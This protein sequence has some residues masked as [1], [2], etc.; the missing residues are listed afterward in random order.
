MLKKIAVLGSTGSVGTQALEVIDTLGFNVVALAYGGNNKKL[1]KKQIEKY[2]PKIA[3]TDLIEA[4][5]VDADIFILSVVGEVGTKAAYDILKKGKILCIATKEVLVCEGKKIMDFAKKHNAEIRPLDSE[6]SAIWQCLKGE[7]K[8]E[9][10]KIFLTCSGGPFLDAKKWT[11]EKL[12]NVDKSKVLNHPKW[13]MGQKITVDSATLIN[14]ALEFIEVC[15]LFDVKPEQ[16][17]VV[18]HPEAIIHS[19]VQFKD[20]SVIAQ[21]SPPDMKLPIAIALSYPE[22]KHLPYS[23]LNIFDI[24]PLNFFPVDKKRFPSIELAKKAILQNKCREFNLANE[25]AVKDFLEDKITFSD[26]FNKVKKSLN[27]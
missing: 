11:L 1:F 10:E 16:I 25:K 19:A 18:I 5:S 8:S 14:K 20:G 26:I 22:R 13:K 3:T 21:M 4:S 15:V 17:E 9:I 23:R 12:K 27:K 7:N 2:K 24:S 6:H